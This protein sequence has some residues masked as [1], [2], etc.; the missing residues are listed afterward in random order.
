[1]MKI[2]GFLVMAALVVGGMGC[3]KHAGDSADRLLQG[4]QWKLT[5][6]SVSSLN[7]A[8]FTITA[9][10]ADGRISGRSGVNQYSGPCK[11]GPGR[12]FSVGPLVSTLMA[13]PEPA[14]RAESAYLMLLS[15]AKSYAL[16]GGR[17]TLYD[18]G[19]NESLI[20][21]P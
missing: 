10:F 9:T 11:I 12:A 15:E 16:S 19:G 18:A 21:A 20:F 4:T 8:D 7:P 1:M 17:L 14:M 5:G 6:W 3:E 2:F 13:G